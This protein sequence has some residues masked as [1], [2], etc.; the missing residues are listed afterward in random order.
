MRFRLKELSS[1]HIPSEDKR[2]S[3]MEKEWSQKHMVAQSVLVFISLCMILTLYRFLGGIIVASLGA[4]SFILFVTPHT[5]TSRAI[6][7]IGG[8]LFGSVSG[9]AFAYLYKTLS[10]LEFTGKDFAMVAVCAFAAAVTTL[11]MILTRL[12]HPPSAALALGLTTDPNSL[13]IAVAA[14][15]GVVILCSIRHLLKRYLKNLL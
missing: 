11:L 9:V 15:G 5:N 10:L 12:V 13:I 2:L 14:V 1:S 7:L 8:Y 3:G 6:N 4:S